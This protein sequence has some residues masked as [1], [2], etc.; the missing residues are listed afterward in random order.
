[1]MILQSEFQLSTL[2]LKVSRTIL[3]YDDTL[4][5]AKMTGS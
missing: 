1:M 5:E 4:L 2:S 3:K